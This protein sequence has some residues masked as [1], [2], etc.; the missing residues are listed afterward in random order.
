MEYLYK[1]E[2]EA[3]GEYFSMVHE[4]QNGISEMFALVW[5]DRER[6]YFIS[7]ASDTHP[8][9]AY[10]RERYRP[11]ATGVEKISITVP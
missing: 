5:M 8:G 1:I 9:T 7:T 4:D 10:T 3:R 6:R 2:L 11:V